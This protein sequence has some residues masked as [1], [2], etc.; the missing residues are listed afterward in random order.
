[1]KKSIKTKIGNKIFKLLP[2]R[3]N[4]EDYNEELEKIIAEIVRLREVRDSEVLIGLQAKL[5]KLKDQDDF[6]L[7][8]KLILEILSELSEVEIWTF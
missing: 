2:M 7:F 8:R 5:L 6:P 1:M 3:E 4:N